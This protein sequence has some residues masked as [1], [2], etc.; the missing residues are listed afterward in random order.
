MKNF[1]ILMCA[2]FLLG[3]TESWSDYENRVDP[4]ELSVPAIKFYT[5]KVSGMRGMAMV[6]SCT[7][8]IYFSENGYGLVPR[9]DSLGK[10]II[11]TG[12]FPK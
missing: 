3:C 2:V 9:I 11:Y 12:E 10:P 6:D 4:I 8:V 5:I 1:L 7:R